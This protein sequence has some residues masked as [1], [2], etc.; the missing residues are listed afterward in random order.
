MNNKD[1]EFLLLIIAILLF[2][3]SVKLDVNNKLLKQI[4]D[5]QQCEG[6]IK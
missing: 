6:K 2:C 1:S 5:V 4:T 3:I